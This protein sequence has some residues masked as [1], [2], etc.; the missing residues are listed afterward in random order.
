D[1]ADGIELAGAQ[2]PAPERECRRA[3]A[4]VRWAV[5][6]AHDGPEAEASVGDAIG[7]DLGPRLERVERATEVA[8]RL[9]HEVAR[10]GSRPAALARAPRRNRAEQEGA[11]LGVGAL[12]VE[13]KVDRGDGGTAPHPRQPRRIEVVRFLGAARAVL[14]Q[15]ERKGAAPLGGQQQ[16]AGDAVAAARVL[17]AQRAH[18]A[19]ARRRHLP[20]PQRRRLAEVGPRDGF[21]ARHGARVYRASSSL[22]ARYRCDFTASSLLRMRTAI[23]WIER[24]SRWCKAKSWRCSSDR[25]EAT[26]S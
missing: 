3:R 4:R 26:A 13:R 22:R 25:S 23:S 6:R 21:R 8:E 12:A 16:D 9:P 7:V 11:E 17:E 2:A 1:V 19:R 24:F 20:H 10:Q 5:E 14:E 18:A 15:D